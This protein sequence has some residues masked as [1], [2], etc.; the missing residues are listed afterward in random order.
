MPDAAPAAG[1]SSA[2]AP[3]PPPPPAA[4]APAAAPAVVNK[5]AAPAT[6]APQQQAAPDAKPPSTPADQAKPG[7]SAPELKLP[8]GWKKDDPNLV[9]FLEVAKKGPLTPQSVVDFYAQVQAKQGEQL[10]QL[11]AADQAELQKELG[12][13]YDD[14]IAASRAV[15]Q[16]I[17]HGA[18]VSKLLEAHFLHHNPTFV[19]FLA[20]LRPLLSEDTIAGR[21]GPNGTQPLTRE[22]ELQKMFPNSPGMFKK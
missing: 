18:E 10:K 12:V 15:L 8:D 16:N 6:P 1:P 2:A 20:A 19:K 22:Q 17:Q 7:E 13:K 11:V 5:D 4:G 9:S 14:T 21:T 3:P